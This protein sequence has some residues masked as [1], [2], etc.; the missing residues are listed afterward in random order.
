MKEPATHSALI[1]DGHKKDAMYLAECFDRL[2]EVKINAVICQD[3]PSAIQSLMQNQANIVFIDYSFIDTDQDTLSNIKSVCRNCSTVTI[4]QEKTEAV[5]LDFLRNEIDEYLVKNAFT[6]SDLMIVVHR[7]LRMNTLRRGYNN[8]VDLKRAAEQEVC[9]YGR[10]HG[11]RNELWQ[12]VTGE[13]KTPELIINR[14]LS[15]VGGIFG[16]SRTSY[17]SINREKTFAVC[18]L[19]WTS[20][21]VASTLGEKI[22]VDLCYSFLKQNDLDSITN[23]E[24]RDFGEFGPL[25]KS[26]LQKNG[27]KSFLCM[28]VADS[29]GNIAGFYDFADCNYERK[30]TENDTAFLKEMTRLISIKLDQIATENKKAQIEEDIHLCQKMEAI[31]QLAGGV[32][33]DFNNILGAISGYAEMIRHKF[34]VNNPKLEKYC[35]TII[36]ATRRAADLT[37]QLLTFAKKSQFRMVS[38]DVHEIINQTINL[39]RQSLKDNIAI[40]NEFSALRTQITGDMTRLQTALLNLGMNARDAMINGGTLTFATSNVTINKFI[41][42]AEDSIACGEYIVVSISDTGIGMDQNIKN[43]IFEPFFSTKDA[44]RGSGLDLAEVYGTIKAHKGY[45]R[46][47]SETGQGSTIELYLPLINKTPSANPPNIIA[48]PFQD[49]PEILV[50]DDEELMRNILQEMLILLGYRVQLAGNGLVG[51][52]IYKN[53]MAEINL[54][55]I[56]MAMNE[57]TGIQCM[58]ELKKVNPDIKAILSS[59]Y[60]LN[61]KIREIENEG[62]SGILQKPFENQE[63]LK[64]IN[65]ALAKS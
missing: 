8:A 1:I 22:P 7:A 32:A 60:D 50:I 12:L 38:C 42:I 2:P 56:D 58:R 24:N 51:I 4:I 48:E 57:M 59:G 20:K 23:S 64:V 3:I 33:H 63:L 46:V 19:Q 26:F 62:F 27:I 53:K 18:E 40:K 13:S 43:R 45:C 10:Y 17:F 30:W 5:C 21:N 65:N 14:F 25:I 61:Q 16:L 6:K 15:S 54:V 47:S 29:N 9:T 37:A 39:L 49:K 36:S 34:A 55:I 31:S 44:G 52:E 28:S 35:T 11:V 41:N